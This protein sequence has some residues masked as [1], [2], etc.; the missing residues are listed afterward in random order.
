[1][2]GFGPAAAVLTAIVLGLPVL[3]YAVLAIWRA[4]RPTAS[5]AFSARA[6][7]VPAAWTAL[8]NVAVAGVSLLAVSD[9]SMYRPASIDRAQS[10]VLVAGL[11]G[12]VVVTF[13]G[14]AAAWVVVAARRPQP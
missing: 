14:A 2:F 6:V 11:G 4:V 3:V 13:L 12:V 10:A 5:T 7:L 8:V 1:M 9:S